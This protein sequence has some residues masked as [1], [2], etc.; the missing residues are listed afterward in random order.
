MSSPGHS[1]YTPNTSCLELGI[2]EARPMQSVP[3]A[4]H[5]HNADRLPISKFN[6]LS[7]LLLVRSGIV[8]EQEKRVR[9]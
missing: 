2:Q 9:L 8:P 6:L 5:C 4:S 7:W 1:R 3:A